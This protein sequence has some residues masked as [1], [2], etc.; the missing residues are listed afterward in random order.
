MA[1]YTEEQKAELEALRKQAD[2]MEI[3]YSGNTSL[4][5]LREKVAERLGTAE[6]QETEADAYQK[7]YDEK[8]RLIHCKVV[9]LD[10]MYKNSGGAFVTVSN[11]V[12]GSHKWFVPF[13]TPVELTK[14]C[15]DY[16]QSC[17]YVDRSE[18]GVRGSNGLIHSKT[19]NTDRAAYNVEILPQLTMEEIKRLADEQTATGRLENKE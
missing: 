8:M 16:L 2:L 3:P 15:V 9:C 18:K 5:K 1:N 14:W 13:N 7:L 4:E 6:E 19:V 17:I 12:L 10:P 11:A